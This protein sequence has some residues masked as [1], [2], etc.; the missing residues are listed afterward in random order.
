MASF[1]YKGKIAYNVYYQYTEPSPPSVFAWNPSFLSPYA[2][3]DVFSPDYY[4]ESSGVVSQW[5]DISGNSRN[6]LQLTTVSRPTL[7][8]NQLNGFSTIRFDGVD[9]HFVC[10]NF[11]SASTPV[12]T[13]VIYKRLSSNINA[14]N[15]VTF[16]CSASG[17]DASSLR[18]LFQY[19][20]NDLTGFQFN[21]YP[22]NN[23]GLSPTLSRTGFD[24]FNIHLGVSDYTNIYYEVNGGSL[25]RNDTFSSPLTPWTNPTELLFGAGSNWGNAPLGRAFFANI[26]VAEF[27]VFNKVLT[28]EEQGYLVGYLAWKWN[29]VSLLPASHPWKNSPVFLS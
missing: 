9:D 14:N 16:V 21:F 18:R 20:F 7:A 19:N 23:G 27:I 2:W 1:I 8:T 22:G 28:S 13:A 26:D 6:L 3:Y 10:D 24:G 29:L 5:L 25:F 11:V 17:V 4:V 12:T 15:N